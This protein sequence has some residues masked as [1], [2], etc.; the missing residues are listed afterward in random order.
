MNTI[1]VRMRVVRGQLVA[2]SKAEK[3][4]QNTT[5]ILQDIKKCQSEL[6]DIYLDLHKLYRKGRTRFFE[7]ETR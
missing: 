7:R 5:Q 2:L 4:P 3:N 1:Q 6:L